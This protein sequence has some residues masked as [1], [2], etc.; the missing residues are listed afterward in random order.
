M[1]DVTNSS[2]DNKYGILFTLEKH[3]F[4][5]IYIDRCLLYRFLIENK[6][7]EVHDTDSI[8]G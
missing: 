5:H 1:N 3:N 2:I 4:K 8:L 6:S 7:I